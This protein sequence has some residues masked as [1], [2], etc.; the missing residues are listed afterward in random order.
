MT[1]RSRGIYSFCFNSRYEKKLQVS[2]CEKFGHGK[3]VSQISTNVVGMH[4]LYKTGLVRSLLGD[5]W[6]VLD[7]GIGGTPQPDLDENPICSEKAI[8]NI[9]KLLCNFQGLSIVLK[10][11]SESKKSDSEVTF[12]RNTVHH[13]FYSILLLDD[14]IGGADVASFE[15]SH[16]VFL[17]PFNSRLDLVY[18]VC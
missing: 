11:E 10:G 2:K 6:D 12:D 18:C 15:D 4:A 17:I 1:T 8:S 13:I 16:I 14:R 3:L 5:F 9:V 7:L